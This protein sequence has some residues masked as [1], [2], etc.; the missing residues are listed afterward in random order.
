V[1]DV[2]FNLPDLPFQ[3]QAI[4]HE[5]PEGHGFTG[6]V[7]VELFNGDIYYRA[8][9]YGFHSETIGWFKEELT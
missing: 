2:D 7:R 6:W 4:R 3:I 8:K 9:G 5:G 1:G